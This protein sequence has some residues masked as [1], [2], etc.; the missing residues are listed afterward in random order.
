[1]LTADLEMTEAEMRDRILSIDSGVYI[2]D[3]D[4]IEYHVWEFFKWTNNTSKR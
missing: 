4:E 1:M 3:D 2:L